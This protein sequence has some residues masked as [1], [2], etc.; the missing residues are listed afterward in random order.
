MK[1]KSNTKVQFE[2]LVKA[3]GESR[4]YNPSREQVEYEIG[5]RT[6]MKTI[7]KKVKHCSNKHQTKI[8]KLM[9]LYPKIIFVDG[10]WCR[11]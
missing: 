2:G 6:T 10:I 5:Q 11:K 3:D 8:V 1:K 9:C 7:N 4:K